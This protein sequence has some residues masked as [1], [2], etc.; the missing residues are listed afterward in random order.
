MII[1]YEIHFLKSMLLSVFIETVVI[2]CLVRLTF[3]IDRQTV[4]DKRLILSGMIPTVMTIPY[5]WFI[6]PLWV[7]G[8]MELMIVGEPLVIICE[9]IILCLILPVTKLRGFFLSLSAN[10]LS[11]FLGHLIARYSTLFF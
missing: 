10:S 2:Y 5:L 7:H 11:L 1:T 6:L 4:S 8:N 9:L 3:K